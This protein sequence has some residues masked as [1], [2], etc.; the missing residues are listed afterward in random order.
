MRLHRR[1]SVSNNCRPDRSLRQSGP[2]VFFF[3]CA[4]APLVAAQTAFTQNSAEKITLLKRA[5]VIVRTVDREGNPLLQGSGFF[6]AADRIV[7]NM[8]VIKD[9]GLIHIETFDGN[10]S[11]I[12]NVV[13]VNEREDLALL[14][15][16]APCADATIL[17]LAD[18]APVEGEAIVVMSN[19]RGSQ[20]KLTGGKVG[21][22][23][24][25]KGTG[26]RIQITAS[27][28]PG[29]SG[30]PVVNKEGRVVGIAVMHLQST[31]D[32]NFAVPARSLKVLQASTRT[33]TFRPSAS[34]R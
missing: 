2:M 10:T 26:N 11:T 22:I 3:L 27:I 30:G 12:R 18:S 5:V 6:I 15:M 20:W 1:S 24:E 31:D 29:S 28:L 19:P 8:H 25:F 32:L 13:A 4:F 23:W 14:Q 17:Q 16:E 9:A 34:G 21:P 7:T 33:A